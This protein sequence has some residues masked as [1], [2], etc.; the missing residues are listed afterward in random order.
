MTVLFTT[1]GF[2]EKFQVRAVMRWGRE[3]EE[4]VIMGSFEEER[5]KK[6]LDSLTNLLKTTNIKY[7]V[8]EVNPHDI[9][10]AVI[11]IGNKIE[12]F[13][14]KKMVFNLSGG[15]RILMLASLLA[16]LIKDVDATIEVETEDMKYLAT[17]EVRDF[18]PVKLT[19]DHLK[20]LKAISEGFNSVNSIRNHLDM[21]L[22]TVW[23]RVRDLKE[24]GLV[25]ENLKLTFKGELVVRSSSFS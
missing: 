8:L 3:L 1:L 7:E 20:V 6:A 13:K 24:M 15:M 14:G 5:A 25:D 10:D 17:V 2:D 18:K 22:S 23:R 21:P 19:E 9:L 12:E 11:K 16:I 4:V